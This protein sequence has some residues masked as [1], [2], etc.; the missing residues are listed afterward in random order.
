M[1]SNPKAPE[2][3][4]VVPAYNEEGNIGLVIDA[5]TQKMQ[6]LERDF[7]I[8]VVDDGSHDG[9]IEEA[10][11]YLT[12]CPLRIVCLSRNFGKEDAIMAGLESSLGKA[13]IVIDADMQE[14]VT[15]MRQFIEYWDQGYQMVYAV[16]AHRDDESFLKTFGSNAFYWLIN[17]MTTVRIPP[18]A[19]DFRLMDR[20]VVDAILGLPEK[21]RFMK[22][23]FNWVGFKT[24]EIEVVIDNRNQGKSSFNY[25]RLAALALTGITSFS[26]WPL[27]VWTAI[28]AVIS[29]ISICYAIWIGFHT[30]IWGSDLPGWTTLSVAIFFLG[31]IQILSIGILGEYISRIFCEVKGRPGHIIA[32]EISYLDQETS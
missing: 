20:K 19:R 11:S 22:G 6:R 29:L 3:S 16:R 5:I 1:S 32:Q 15:T 12:Q 2:I 28:G 25:R 13:V 4:C 27:R 7:E 14:P 24:K 17:K 30:L 9:T 18:H 23:L 10:K 31:G 8:I 21:K 26:D